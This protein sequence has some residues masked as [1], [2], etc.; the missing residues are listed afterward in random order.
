MTR[1]LSL[2]LSQKTDGAVFEYFPGPGRDRPG[3]IVL[4]KGQAVL[5]GAHV[6]H[7]GAHYPVPDEGLFL[8]VHF[9]LQ[10]ASRLPNA[11][12]GKV[13]LPEFCST[14]TEYETDETDLNGVTLTELACGCSAAYEDGK[15]PAA[16]SAEAYEL[17]KFF[18]VN[19]AMWSPLSANSDTQPPQQSP[20]IS[21]EP[22]TGLCDM[23]EEFEQEKLDN[24]Q[25]VKLRQGVILGQ[26]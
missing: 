12:I 8:R 20:S 23:E 15:T 3:R 2:C 10:L 26:G 18:R 13:H 25:R 6:E 24:P 9:Y 7:N 22:S 11:D 16:L 4:K 1:V 5:F 17:M 14:T 21:G 19:S